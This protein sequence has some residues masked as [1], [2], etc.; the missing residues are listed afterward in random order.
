MD[1]LVELRRTDYI[2]RVWGGSETSH[3]QFW[4]HLTPTINDCIYRNMFRFTRI[5]V[6]DFDEVG[7]SDRQVCVDRS[8]GVNATGTLGGRRSSAE[9]AR[10]EAP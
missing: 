6:M 4:L 3:D 5:A 8:M 9:D 10:I 1:G 7:F 2:G